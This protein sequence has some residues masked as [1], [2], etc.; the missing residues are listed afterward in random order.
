MG[1]EKEDVILDENVF[2]MCKHVL[3]N[4]MPIKSEKLHEM[5][6]LL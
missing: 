4:F 1:P 5:G 3:C 6:D 2:K